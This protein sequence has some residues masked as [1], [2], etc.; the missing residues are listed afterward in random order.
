ME[1]VEYKVETE[2]LQVPG[3]TES[4]CNEIIFINKSGAG[5]IV[6][7]DGF[8][9]DNNEYLLDGGNIG[10]LNKSRYNITSSAANFRLYVRR[11][12]YKK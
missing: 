8:P 11:K 9:L 5:I 2:V 10:E 7:V 6:S 1:R 4:N 12:I 3:A